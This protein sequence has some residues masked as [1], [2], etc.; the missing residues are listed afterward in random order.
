MA[1]II[2]IYG[3]VVS[4]IIGVGMDMTNYTPYKGEHRLTR[5]G[6]AS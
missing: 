3:L 5:R 4:V 6:R 1:G 2:A